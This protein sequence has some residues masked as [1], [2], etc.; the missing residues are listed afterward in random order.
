MKREPAKAF[1]DPVTWISWVRG[2][3][4]VVLSSDS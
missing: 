1:I 4:F 3:C 2:G